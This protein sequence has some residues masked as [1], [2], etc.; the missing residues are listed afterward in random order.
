[1]SVLSGDRGQNRRCV[2]AFAHGFV[3]CEGNVAHIQDVLQQGDGIHWEIAKGVLNRPALRLFVE[4]RYQWQGR[5]ISG[6]RSAHP[7]KQQSLSAR[8]WQ[9]GAAGSSAL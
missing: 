8:C 4:N 5:E 7:D 1:M 6:I 9:T 3:V 2:L